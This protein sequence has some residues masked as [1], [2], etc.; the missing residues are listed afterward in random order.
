MSPKIS[1]FNKHSNINLELE[2]HRAGS[3]SQGKELRF[4]NH[5]EKTCATLGVVAPWSAP[6]F[7]KHQHWFRSR[8]RLWHRYLNFKVARWVL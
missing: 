1:A 5:A 4:S 2:I 6:I 8:Y 3:L 7:Q